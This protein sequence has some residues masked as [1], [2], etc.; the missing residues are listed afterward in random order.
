MQQNVNLIFP[1]FEYG[2]ITG[3][4]PADCL[5][6]WYTLY[7]TPFQDQGRPPLQL[8]DSTKGVSTPFLHT[9]WSVRVQVRVLWMSG[10]TGLL[11]TEPWQFARLLLHTGQTSRYGMPAFTLPGSINMTVHTQPPNVQKVPG[12]YIEGL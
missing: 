4:L 12:E 8:S 10:S 11:Q 3:S 9:L 6:S 2:I 1:T 5:C 7:I